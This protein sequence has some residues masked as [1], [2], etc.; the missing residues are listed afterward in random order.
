MPYIH[1]SI[2]RACTAEKAEQFKKDMGEA[3]TVFPG[4]TEAWL[5][6]GLQEEKLWF[7]GN[8]APAAMVHVSVLGKL[9]HDSCEQMTARVCDSMENCFGIPAD[10]VY[11]K[12]DATD[13]WGWN[14]QNF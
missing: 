4:K 1:A 9:N 11:V 7:K 6:V 12:Y 10:R 14:R 3:I 2:N 8:D 5:M 13:E